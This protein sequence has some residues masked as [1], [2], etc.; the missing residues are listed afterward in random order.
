MHQWSRIDRKYDD[1]A[2]IIHLNFGVTSMTH[3]TNFC[4]F[5]DVIQHET[6][7]NHME[8]GM[9]TEEHIQLAGSHHENPDLAN[10][11]EASHRQ[12]VSS[13]GTQCESDTSN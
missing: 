4:L 7:K 8:V 6:G 1:L 5:A 2:A 13:N 12:S 11:P 3:C 9:S 10:A